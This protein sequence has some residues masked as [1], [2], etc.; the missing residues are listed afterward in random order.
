MNMRQKFSSPI[1]ARNDSD[2]DRHRA[3]SS[4]ILETSV[5]PQ[6][7]NVQNLGRGGVNKNLNEGE[8]VAHDSFRQMPSMPNFSVPL[9]APSLPF[10]ANMQIAPETVCQLLIRKLAANNGLLSL[11][12]ICRILPDIRARSNT[13]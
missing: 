5:N 4:S 3:T 8:E 11:N 13:Q 7:F 9:Q 2:I 6:L 1:K 12:D 10:A